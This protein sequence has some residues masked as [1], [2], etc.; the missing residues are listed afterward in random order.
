MRY[1]FTSSFKNLSLNWEKYVIF[2]EKRNFEPIMNSAHTAERL[3]LEK[4]QNKN[5][6]YLLYYPNRQHTK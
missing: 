4:A 2:W 3:V 6:D 5:I 1:S